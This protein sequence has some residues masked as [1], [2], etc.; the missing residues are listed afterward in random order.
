M[1]LK[2]ASPEEY[3]QIQTDLAAPLRSAIATL[4]PGDLARLKA[5]ALE[6]AAAHMKDGIVQFAAV[7]LCASAS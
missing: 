4:S 6:K 5:K 2:W 7:P 1:T 3:W